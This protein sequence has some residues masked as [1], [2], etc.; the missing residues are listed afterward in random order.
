MKV[1]V[2]ELSTQSWH[3]GIGK[4]LIIKRDRLIHDAK[5]KFV[6]CARG[7]EGTPVPVCEFRTS[8]EF[9]DICGISI[10]QKPFIFWWLD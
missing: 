8:L 4:M 3:L 9:S 2:A 7:R 10:P 1:L 6:V 5:V